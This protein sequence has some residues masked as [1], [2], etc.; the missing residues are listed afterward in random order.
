MSSTL[1]RI[2]TDLTWSSAAN[3][4]VPIITVGTGKDAVKYYGIRLDEDKA[5]ELGQEGGKRGGRSERGER[6]AARSGG[7]DA[8]RERKYQLLGIRQQPPHHLLQRGKE[9]GTEEE[10]KR[11]ETERKSEARKWREERMKS[12]S[13]VEAKDADFTA[14]FQGTLARSLNNIEYTI[15]PH[16]DDVIGH[17]T[18]PRVEMVRG[19]HRQEIELISGAVE[20]GLDTEEGSLTYGQIVPVEN[21]STQKRTEKKMVEMPIMERKSVY[22]P[23]VLGLKLWGIHGPSRCEKVAEIQRRIVRV[24]PVEG[25]KMVYENLQGE[26]MSEKQVLK[27]VNTRAA[28]VYERAMHYEYET[29]V[30]EME[31]KKWKEE[32]EKHLRADKEERAAKR[33]EPEREKEVRRTRRR[34]R[35]DTE[36]RERRRGN[37]C[38]T[39][40]EKKEQGEKSQLSEKRRLAQKARELVAR[41]RALREMHTVVYL[42]EDELAE[43][44]RKQFNA[45]SIRVTK[46]ARNERAILSREHLDRSRKLER[47]MSESYEKRRKEQKERRV[48][49]EERRGKVKR[50]DKEEEKVRQRED[51]ELRRLRNKVDEI[52]REKEP[53]VIWYRISHEEKMRKKEKRAMR[54]GRSVERMEVATMKGSMKEALETYMYPE[55]RPYSPRGEEGTTTYSLARAHPTET[56]TKRPDTDNNVVNVVAQVPNR[57]SREETDEELFFKVLPILRGETYTA[58]LEAAEIVES[59]EYTALGEPGVMEI[60]PLEAA[61][62]KRASRRDMRRGDRRDEEA[63]KEEGVYEKNMKDHFKAVR[64]TAEHVSGTPWTLASTALGQTVQEKDNTMAGFEETCEKFAPTM[65]GSFMFPVISYPVVELE[66]GPN[67]KDQASPAAT[68]TYIP[69]LCLGE[70]GDTLKDEMGEIVEVNVDTCTVTETTEA[71]QFIPGDTRDEKRKGRGLSIKFTAGGVE[72]ELIVPEKGASWTATYPYAMTQFANTPYQ[73]TNHPVV[74]TTNNM[75]MVKLGT[76]KDTLGGTAYTEFFS[77]FVDAG[78]LAYKVGN[79]YG[80]VG[81]INLYPTASVTKTETDPAE[82]DK[83]LVGWDNEDSTVAETGKPFKLLTHAQLLPGIKYAETHN[84]ESELRLRV[85]DKGWWS[86]TWTSGGKAVRNYSLSSL[87]QDG[88]SFF[89]TWMETSNGSSIDDWDSSRQAVLCSFNMRGGI[90]ASTLIF[91]GNTFGER[92]AIDGEE[93]KEEEVPYYLFDAFL[94][95]M[96]TSSGGSETHAIYPSSIINTAGDPKS[97][98]VVYEIGDSYYGVEVAEFTSK[99]TAKFDTKYPDLIGLYQL[100][101]TEDHLEGGFSKYIVTVT[102]PSKCKANICL[103]NVD[104]AFSM[105]LHKEMNDSGDSVFELCDIT[106]GE[107]E[108]ASF[109]KSTNST[110]KYIQIRRAYDVLSKDPFLGIYWKNGGRGLKFVGYTSPDTTDLFTEQLE[111]EVRS[112]EITCPLYHSKPRISLEDAC[113]NSKRQEVRMDTPQRMSRAEKAGVE[114]RRKMRESGRSLCPTVTREERKEGATSTIMSD[115]IKVDG[116][117][118]FPNVGTGTEITDAETYGTQFFILQEAD[119]ET[120]TYVYIGQEFE[121]PAGTR[122]SMTT[123]KNFNDVMQGM[124]NSGE[125]SSFTANPDWLKQYISYTGDTTDTYNGIYARV[126]NVTVEPVTKPKYNSEFGAVV[127]KIQIPGRI[128]GAAE[129]GSGDTPIENGKTGYLTMNVE[130]IV[131]PI[132]STSTSLLMKVDGSGVRNRFKVKT[133]SGEE[134]ATAGGSEEIDL[135][136]N[137]FSRLCSTRRPQYSQQM[138]GKWWSL[139]DIPLSFIFK[140]KDQTQTPKDYTKQLKGGIVGLYT[141][142]IDFFDMEKQV[143]PQ[144]ITVAGRDEMVKVNVIEGDGSDNYK[145]AHQRSKGDKTTI[146]GIVDWADPSTNNYEAGGKGVFGRLSKTTPGSFITNDPLSSTNLAANRGIARTLF[147]NKDEKAEFSFDPTVAPLFFWHVSWSISLASPVKRQEGVATDRGD[148]SVTV[149]KPYYAKPLFGWTYGVPKEMPVVG[150]MDTI[151]DELNRYVTTGADGKE[152]IN[153]QFF[154]NSPNANDYIMGRN[155]GLVTVLN[156]GCDATVSRLA[157]VKPTSGA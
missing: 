43:E 145:F 81:T 126:F 146:T 139:G 46:K 62:R 52:E 124:V 106:T 73:Q 8:R 39:G 87:V 49:R 153:R 157:Y 98:D 14:L 4:W 34:P 72:R 51:S 23:T 79:G 38:E 18:C 58:D 141:G 56:L 66:T 48:E 99:F 104:D 111:V 76:E 65:Q 35:K 97:F 134:W 69:H 155:T 57:R 121:A 152:T 28:E 143:I 67:Y 29:K 15:T 107:E 129:D 37:R 13:E 140:P 17:N 119:D 108:L 16:Y 22:S 118:T 149:G 63:R 78:L 84:I 116:I 24:T 109:I 55:T 2:T 70:V 10:R 156:C 85:D 127:S 122:I 91:V 112:N 103:G 54:R 131:Q 33:E 92:M 44:C 53:S 6:G 60:P 75:P 144:H 68:K 59:P 19:M 32:V 31:K 105:Y 47:Q 151:T 100:A 94:V 82:Y 115:T 27:A 120:Y 41:K 150:R 90:V 7:R 40:D 133:S 1:P 148:T 142:V 136:P 12:R 26:R 89:G 42:P 154:I 130:D 30:L 21:P 25:G 86:S 110:Y 80:A 36:C 113:R 88:G 123:M 50:E 96:E 77:Q 61:M 11:Q 117:A 135:S 64:L 93:E 5:R 138:T 102:P 83:S 125:I 132:L 71:K 45:E 95:D 137:T 3:D 20:F 147:T 128:K 114:W 74:T 101:Y 9:K